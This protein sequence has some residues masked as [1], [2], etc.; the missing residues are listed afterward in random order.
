MTWCVEHTNAISTC[1]L[2]YSLIALQPEEGNNYQR[3][4]RSLCTLFG[5]YSN[6]IMSL[7]RCSTKKRDAILPSISLVPPQFGDL[8]QV[9]TEWTP[10]RFVCV[11][12][13]KNV[14]R[15]S[16]TTQVWLPLAYLCKSPWWLLWKWHK[17]ERFLTVCLWRRGVL[18]QSDRIGED[19]EALAVSGA[20]H[21]SHWSVPV[22][23][24]ASVLFPC[25]KLTSLF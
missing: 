9:K 4:S 1:S 10:I 11:A 19:M 23:M 21:L 16:R 24:N 17:A 15:T 2:S 20:L 7:E 5:L 6:S 14:S 25:R 22:L 12:C 13:T 8:E 3:T 18:A